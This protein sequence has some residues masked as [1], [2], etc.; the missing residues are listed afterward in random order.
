MATRTV[1]APGLD[2]V[3][4]PEVVLERLAE[5]AREALVPDAECHLVVQLE[6]AVVEVDRPHGRPG[7]VDHERLCVQHRRLVLEDPNPRL[8]QLLVGG[9]TGDSHEALV[10]VRAGNEDPH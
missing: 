10:D 5:P 6:G 3:R 7:V 4:P 2:L 9:A 1:T 8:E